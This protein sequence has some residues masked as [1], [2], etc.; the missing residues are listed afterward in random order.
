MNSITKISFLALF[1]FIMLNS[2]DNI[3]SPIEMKDKPS[4]QKLKKT[5]DAQQKDIESINRFFLDIKGAESVSLDKPGIISITALSTMP[6]SETELRIVMPQLSAMKIAKEKRG[7]LNRIEIPI[8]QELPSQGREF[9]G[10]SANQRI[11]YKIPLSISEPGYYSI[12]ANIRL[13]NP[14]E[15]STL[16]KEGKW[17]KNSVT[18]HIWIWVDENKTVVTKEFEEDLFPK[19]YLIQ[20]GPL[21]KMGEKPRIKY[22][23][24]DARRKIIVQSDYSD[25][26]IIITA[27]YMDQTT[28]TIKPLANA[29]GTYTIIDEYERRAV[30]GGQLETNAYGE[31]AIGCTSAQYYSYE[32][33][34]FSENSDVLVVNNN[35]SKVVGS[36]RGDYSRCGL[37]YGVSTASDRSHVYGLASEIVKDAENLFSRSRSKILFTLSPNEDNSFYSPGNDQITIAND[38]NGVSHVGGAFGDFVIAH[39]YGHAFHEKALGGNTGGGCPSPHYLSGAHNLQCAYSEGFAN[40]VGAISI[41]GPYSTNI[42]NNAYYPATVGTGDLSDGSRIEGAVAAFFYDITD[43]TSESHDNLDLPGSY[44]ANTIRECEVYAGGSWY[45]ANGVDHLIS[46]FQ[47]Q[48][49]NYSSY[50]DSRISIP[51]SYRESVSEPSGWS[52]SAMK[53]LWK[54]NLYGE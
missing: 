19:G 42:S 15:I 50:F 40:Y 30:A 13:K 11:N 33:Q 1:P 2:C 5:G 17:I 23:K 47:N 6:S 27:T 38:P 7:N 51:S 21:T 44:V 4:K 46:C 12:Y 54:H 52:S 29:D 34:F 45:R 3:S 37:S 18:K 43:N 8:N 48:I 35:G 10:L 20:P 39:E 49:P 25:Y 16:F 32:V 53:S 24:S 36:A 26:N 31:V 14:K 9:Q 22:L 41:S 28:L